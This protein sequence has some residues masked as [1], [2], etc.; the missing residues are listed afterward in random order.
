MAAKE[1]NR[2]ISQTQA[3]TNGTTI[4]IEQPKSSRQQKPKIT[5]VMAQEMNPVGGFLNFVREHAIVGI[6]VGFAIAG[7]VQAIVKQLIAS[8][9]DPLYM[10]F[11]NGQKLSSMSLTLHWHGRQGVF[12]WGAFI[13]AIIDFLFVLAILYLALKIFRLEKLDKTDKKAK[14]N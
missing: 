12:A 7:Q 9:I 4:R 6:A 5:V 3:V 13:Y 2:Q 1:K 8:F 14:G 10:V 11:F